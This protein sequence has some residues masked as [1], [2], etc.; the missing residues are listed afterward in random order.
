MDF[1]VVDPEKVLTY[2]YG[3]AKFYYREA[4][5][6]DFDEVM[7]RALDREG[8]QLDIAGPAMKDAMIRRFVTGWDGVTVNGEA[9]PFDVG[10]VCRI[11]NVRDRLYD[12]I[13]H[14]ALEVPTSPD[15]L[16]TSNS[17]SE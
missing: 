3:D 12:L 6:S 1:K 4:T 17:T 11:R 9:I 14:G 13:V 2:E 5:P 8:E 16:A 15:P 10:V 7:W